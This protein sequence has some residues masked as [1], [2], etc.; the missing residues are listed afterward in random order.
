MHKVICMIYEFLYEAPFIS[1]VSGR[2]EYTKTQSN[3]R[4]LTTSPFKINEF[5]VITLIL[6][7]DI[8]SRIYY[9]GP[10]ALSSRL[11]NGNTKP[12]FTIYN[13]ASN[14]IILPIIL[15]ILASTT[16]Q[17][18]SPSPSPKSRLSQ[19]RTSAASPRALPTLI[20]YNTS[21]KPNLLTTTPQMLTHARIL[22]MN[23]TCC[24]MLQAKPLSPDALTA[25]ETRIALCTKLLDAMEKVGHPPPIPNQPP[26]QL[27]SLP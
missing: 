11:C 24:R 9:D 26:N 3:L 7:I 27:T 6:R 16:L 5:I 2:S 14:L 23:I 18:S 10:I 21:T 1:K 25:L 13:V 17:T 22:E 8:S 4:S 20:P 15:S 12:S 19:H